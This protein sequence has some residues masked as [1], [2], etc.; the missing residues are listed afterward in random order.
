[1]IVFDAVNERR[2]FAPM[3]AIWHETFLSGNDPDVFL[4]ALA[5]V[6]REKVSIGRNGKGLSD[7]VTEIADLIEEWV[8]LNRQ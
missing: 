8:I 7:V 6:L 1:M 3:K 5:A 4:Q 2:D